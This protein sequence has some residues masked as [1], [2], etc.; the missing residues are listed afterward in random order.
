M[1][2]VLNRE[3][4]MICH[5]KLKP[6]SSQNYL[7][8]WTQFLNGSVTS[9]HS[10]T[11]SGPAGIARQKKRNVRGWRGESLLEVTMLI[12]WVVRSVGVANR[13]KDVVKMF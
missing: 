1:L 8:L 2:Q 5:Q 4:V 10:G 11:T 3:T 6:D 9:T 12:I 13:C 7:Q